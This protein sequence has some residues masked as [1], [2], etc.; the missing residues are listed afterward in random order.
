MNYRKKYEKHYNI[1]LSGDE[2]VHHCDADRNNNDVESNLIALPREFHV[3]LHKCIGLLPKPILN[4]L[5]VK[6]KKTG[7]KFSLAALCNWVYNRLKEMNIDSKI[8]K[9]AQRYVSNKKILS[10]GQ[11]HSN[12]FN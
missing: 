8:I 4:E 10:Y 3:A 12:G 7:K 11:Y 9:D 1:I 5:V 2:D 6:Y